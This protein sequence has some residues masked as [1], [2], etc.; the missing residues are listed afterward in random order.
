[1]W[2]LEIL[3]RCEEMVK[4]AETAAHWKWFAMGV[5][6]GAVGLLVSLLV[7][8]WIHSWLEERE[9]RRPIPGYPEKR[10]R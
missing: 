8:G 3:H 7:V 10:G 4:A 9:A 1:M 6:A 5:G 2:P